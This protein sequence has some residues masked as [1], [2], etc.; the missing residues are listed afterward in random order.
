[1]NWSDYWLGVAH[2]MGFL[3]IVCTLVYKLTEN[4]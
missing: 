4:L 2:G 3:I 1:M